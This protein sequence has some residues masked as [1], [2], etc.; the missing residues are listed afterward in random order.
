MAAIIDPMLTKVLRSST[1][2]S[3]KTRDQT[4]RDQTSRDQTSRDQTPHELRHYSA[5]TAEMANILSQKPLLAR[6][7]MC[8]PTNPPKNPNNHN[9]WSTL[10]T[11]MDG[12]EPFVTRGGNEAIFNISAVTGSTGYDTYYRTVSFH[13]SADVYEVVDLVLM[14]K[15]GNFSI[16]EHTYMMTDDTDEASVNDDPFGESTPVNFREL[17]ASDMTTALLL[18]VVFPKLS[19]VFVQLIDETIATRKSP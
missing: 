8:D 5:I 4:S 1:S 12:V 2:M 7:M 16:W 13:C 6:H 3:R 15:T 14:K 10:T 9:A 18:T 11:L 19:E 17:L